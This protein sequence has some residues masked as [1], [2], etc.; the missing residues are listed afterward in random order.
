MGT[1]LFVAPNGQA[2][3]FDDHRLPATTERH[4]VRLQV[5]E[6]GPA[7]D[8]VAE[9][10][11]TPALDGVVL[12]M[13]VGWPGSEYLRLARRVLQR[14]RR[15]WMYWPDE[16]AVECVDRLRLASYWRHI[17]AM[18]AYE[19]VRGPIAAPAGDTVLLR[20]VDPMADPGTAA[21]L[22]AAMF[23]PP[24]NRDAFV[25]PRP[26]PWRPERGTN[27]GC[28]VYL[29]LDF[30]NQFD[31][32]GSYGHTCYVAK[33]LAAATERFVCFLGQRYALLDR[34]GVRQV[35]PDAPSKTGAE[36]DL[37]A[38]TPYYYQLLKPA[39]EA[40]RPAYIYERI[41]LGNYAGALLA[42]ELGIPYVVE[43]NGSEIS[44][45]R[46]F[47]TGG[48]VHE[49]VFTRAEDLA[50]RQATVISVI[51]AE[52]K[53]TL[54]ERGVDERKILTNPNG[55][56]TD[57]YAPLP[58]DRRRALRRELEF[59][60]NDVVVGF[61]GTFGGWHGVGVLAAA[62]PRICAGARE[63]KFLLIGDGA[64][65]HLVDAA[66]E[67]TRN[68]DR[69]RAVGRV[70]QSEGARLLP[71]CDIFVSPHSAHMKDSRFFGSPTKLFEY[72][73]VGGGIVASD[74]EQIGQVLSPALRPHQIRTAEPVHDERAVLCGPGN[75]E[76]L[77]D[78]V[79]ALVQRPD[80]RRALGR[81]ARAAACDHYS[82]RRHV[83]NLLAFAR[84][85]KSESELLGDLLKPVARAVYEVTVIDA[86]GGLAVADAITVDTG[87][88]YKDEVQRQWNSNPAGSHY[89]KDAQPHTLEWFLE[90]E[91]YRYDE[92]AP[93]MPDLMEFAAHRG[94]RV[95]E[96]GG[97]MGTDLAQFAAGGATVTD[98]DLSLGH[99]N[100]AKE[101]FR[102]RGLTGEFIHQDAEH[103]PVGDERFDVVYSNGVLHHTPNT[104][105]VV[106]E[107]HRVLKPG[108]T[109]IIMFYAES[110]LHYWW[111][112]VWEIGL[113]RGQLLQ[114]SMGDIMSSKVEITENEARP[115]V[116]V[117]TK[118]QLRAMFSR[119]ARVRIHQRQL[120]LR[121]LPEW[122]R[123]APLDPAGRLMGW[124][125]IVK[126]QKAR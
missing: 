73:A 80:I 93:W 77:V 105:Q 88:A 94:D 54:V 99:L 61:S 36:R 112:L 20:A 108:G 22:S 58:D 98:V 86:G 8:V 13:Y 14:G 4:R 27:P 24:S 83:D 42:Q 96:I 90:A 65:K 119:F 11:K 66:T 95:L 57:A 125:L 87:D 55:V 118:R 40:L 3:A 122:L 2:A 49:D 16:E 114:H 29:R 124:N 51:S 91:H 121:D 59:T 56:D 32:G 15:V 35:V 25:D 18:K 126:A 109:A 68:E 89:V 84:H 63:A 41:C 34:M 70:P 123:W 23:V 116:K 7:V 47:G 39:L 79:L 10:E 103:L 9:L 117:Y 75:V 110:S 53:S 81:N 106:D 48:L 69:V 1:Y 52:V 26:V 76:E 30:W 19:K 104:T 45:Q 21:A 67:R 101:N 97:G 74:L 5:P 50:F 43:Y 78:A 113:E 120:I 37:L 38:A 62:L 31:S 12:Q 60:D 46:S 85:E 71:A 82:W 92:Y 115:L 17:L 107:I 102:L 72:M 6:L 28:G 44:M 64:Q 100:H 111:K 33:E